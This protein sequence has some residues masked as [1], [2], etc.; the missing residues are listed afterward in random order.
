MIKLLLFIGKIFLL[1]LITAIVLDGFYSFVY[2]NGRNRGKIDFVYNSKPQNFDVVI[3]GS[4][5]ANNHFV[6]PLFEAK[7]LKTFNFGMSGSHLFEASL[8]LKLMISNKFKIK[9]IIIETDLNLCSEEQADGISSRFL[10]YIR[11]SEVVR[12]HFQGT[13]DFNYLYYIPF[14]RYLKFETKIGVREMFFSGINKKTNHLNN[15][16]Y[17][18]L[19]GNQNG[20]MKSNLKALV[21]LPRN[22]YY[23]EIKRI[24]AKNNIRL[25]AVMTPMC[26]NLVGI[27]YFEKVKKT[28][29]EVYNYE[30]VVI[31][32]ENFSS[33][34]H[35]NDEGAKKF[36][37]IILKDFF[38]K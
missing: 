35:L 24:C 23:L 28:Y 16:G 2:E 17:S 27:D 13:Q 21:P 6:A 1:F 33:C 3:L 38:N 26:E 37:K 8:L 7:G 25:I 32:N 34:G 29:P 4:S 19:L 18:P 36:T 20:N 10:P 31:E 14:Y 22:K 30:N 5:R 15:L 11:S 9:N 12:K